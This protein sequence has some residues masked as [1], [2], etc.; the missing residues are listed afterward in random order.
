MLDIKFIVENTE[1]VKEGLLKKG[2]TAEDI[3]I[4]NL[5]AL[6]KNVTKLKTSTQNLAEEKNRLSNSIKSASPEERPSIISKSKEIGEQLK[7]EQ[8]LL[9]QEQEKFDNI[10]WRMPNLPCPESPVAPDDSGNVVIKKF[11]EPTKFNFTPKDHVELMEL[12]DWSELERITKVSGARTYAIKN[13]L[14]RL[15]LAMHML[16]LDKLAEH[17]FTTITVP[18]ISKQKPLYG[19]GYLPFAKDE[20]YYM[21]ADDLYLSGTAELVLN[22]LRADEILTENDL[23]VLYAGFSPCFRREAGAAGKDTRGL[24]RVHQFLKTEQFVICKNDIEESYKWHKKLLQISEEV[25]QDLE[26]PYQVLEICTGD[27]GAPKYRQYDLEAWTPSQNC[28]RETHSCSN[29]TE[30]QARRTNLRYRDNKDGKVKFAHTL[31]NTGIA[32]PRILAPFIENHQQENGSV[33]IPEK[34][35]PYMNGKKFIGK[36]A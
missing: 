22:S 21:P 7:T 15:E 11:G 10:M 6:H 36:N 24:V 14:S 33:R 26:L 3:N 8:D 13:E 29:I 34:L 1:L 4:D 17:G 28:Y 18:S 25:L 27:M 2:Y 20:I 12:N 30:W 32:T 31:N 19:M 5:I 9:V 23:P 35:Q 16:V